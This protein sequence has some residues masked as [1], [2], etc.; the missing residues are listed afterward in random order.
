MA[1]DHDRPVPLTSITGR[2]QDVLMLVAEGA[3]NVEIADRLVISVR[4]VKF[5]LSNLLHKLGARDRAHLIALSFRTGLL[6]ATVPR[7]GSL[8]RRTN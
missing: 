5:H 4:T 6:T 8:R 7:D 3:A 1:D 2:E